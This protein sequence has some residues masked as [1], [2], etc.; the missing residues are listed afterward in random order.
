MFVNGSSVLN[1][2]RQT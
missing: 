2:V 1:A